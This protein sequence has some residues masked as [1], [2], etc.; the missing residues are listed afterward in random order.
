MV[1]Q[2]RKAAW[3]FT[4]VLHFLAR[5]QESPPL[6]ECAPELVISY[7][8]LISY[9]SPQ[10]PSFLCFLIED[11]QIFFYHPTFKFID[12]ISPF[13]QWPEHSLGFELCNSTCPLPC[14]TQSALD[15]PWSLKKI[16]SMVK[17]SVSS[18]RQ[19]LADPILEQVSS[20][21]FFFLKSLTNRFL[22]QIGTC[23]DGNGWSGWDRW[24]SQVGL[25]HGA[26]AKV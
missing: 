24:L 12:Y 10:I 22:C 19:P 21:G 18:S 8:S 9:L 7:F 26:W 4:S 6:G 1:I 20:L 3:W 5:F 14:P 11:S 17:E 16:S 13:L 15:H 2:N 25:R 23:L